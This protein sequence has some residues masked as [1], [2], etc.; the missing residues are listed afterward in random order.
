MTHNIFDSLT[1]A[2]GTLAPAHW[3]DF[4]ASTTENTARPLPI[5]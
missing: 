4:A 1:T 3:S 5:H 2:Q